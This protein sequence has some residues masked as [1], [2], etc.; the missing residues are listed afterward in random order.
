M[1]SANEIP[2]A[3]KKPAVVIHHSGGGL[4]TLATPE[5]ALAFAQGRIERAADLS[6]VI[7]KSLA[8]ADPAAANT[9][10]LLTAMLFEAKEALS[11]QALV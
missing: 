9:L 11:H 4:L 3:S 7:G 2:E 10:Q 8:A 1:S 6:E 5:E